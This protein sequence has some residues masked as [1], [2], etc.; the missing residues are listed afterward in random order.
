[1]AAG[2]AVMIDPHGW[3]GAGF[4]PGI[5]G[6]RVDAKI[7]SGLAATDPTASF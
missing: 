4:D 6:L 7:V 1:M 2:L 3:D 5:N